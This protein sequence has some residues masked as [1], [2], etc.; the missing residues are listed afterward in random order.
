VLA[1]EREREADLLGERALRRQLEAHINQTKATIA[2]G[3]ATDE[4]LV[5]KL[6]AQLAEA[7]RGLPLRL[8]DTNVG[9]DTGDGRGESRGGGGGGIAEALERM[10]GDLQELREATASAQDDIVNGA[11]ELAAAAADRDDV[12]SEVRVE[13]SVLQAERMKLTT[14][15]RSTAARID[16]LADGALSLDV[17]AG[18]GLPLVRVRQLSVKR[19]TRSS[20]GGGSE[21]GSPGESEATC[22]EL[23]LQLLNVEKQARLDVKTA[24]DQHQ[25]QTDMAESATRA[26]E[27]QRDEARRARDVAI[28]S[29]EEIKQALAMLE[30]QHPKPGGRLTRANDTPS[31]M[32]SVTSTDESAVRTPEVSNRSA[33]ASSA[34]LTQSA[35]QCKDLEA[36]VEKLRMDLS[37][38]AAENLQTQAYGA[39]DIELRL[40]LES[41][42]KQLVD[43]ALACTEVEKTMQ[44]EIRQVRK[45]KGIPQKPKN[46]QKH[47]KSPLENPKKAHNIQKKKPRNRPKGS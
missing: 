30:A 18:G 41:I 40:E 5:R 46:V 23:Q 34:L 7:R 37:Q 44:R 16:A 35:A 15:A 10:R 38:S 3:C 4:A 36:Q 12:L 1:A 21:G 19:P 39:A 26:A 28:E 8:S 17:D 29:F 14:H 24:A 45:P 27:A 20:N 33:D 25:R 11:K 47:P 32:S 22:S 6:R 31:E 9:D 42:N 43:E 13:L 2:E